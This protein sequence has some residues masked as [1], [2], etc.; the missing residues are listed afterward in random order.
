MLV[1]ASLPQ[2]RPDSPRF[3]GPLLTRAG[4]A[5][6]LDVRWGR[7]PQWFGG[8]CDLSGGYLLA[9]LSSHPNTGTMVPCAEWSWWQRG[10][11]CTG[12]GT[13]AVPRQCS[14]HRF[15][16]WPFTQPSAKS[17]SEP[18][19]GRCP[20]QQNEQRCF[21]KVK[22]IP[23]EDHSLFWVRSFYFLVWNVFYLI[24]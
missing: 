8:Q 21:H 16:G 20:G 2:S 24:A 12:T 14:L 7:G 18:P 11:L 9:S 22:Q 1:I 5:A 13:R 19:L 6:P 23:L 10:Q 15:R 3:F 4:H 17:N